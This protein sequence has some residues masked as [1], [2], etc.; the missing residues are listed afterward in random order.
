[1][2]HADRR[3][4]TIDQPAHPLPGHPMPLTASPQTVEPSFAYMGPERRQHA[5]VGR[6]REVGEVSPRHGAEPA[7]P[8]I[9]RLVPV[10]AKRLRDLIESGSHSLALSPAPLHTPPVNASRATPRRPRMT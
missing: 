8:L 9:D 5:A 10:P 3:Q 7:S 6:H 4:E 2:Q 1:M